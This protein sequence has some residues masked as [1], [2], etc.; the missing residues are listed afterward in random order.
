MARLLSGET[1]SYAAA[2]VIRCESEHSEC[3][4]R[5]AA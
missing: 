2:S 1:D 5:S 3:T 4:V